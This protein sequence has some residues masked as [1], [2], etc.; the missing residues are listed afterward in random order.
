[1]KN[2]YSTVFRKTSS[3]SENLEYGVKNNTVNLSCRLDKAV[4]NLLVSDA[5]KRGISINSLVN[6]IAKKYISWERHA[7]DIGFVPL[8]KRAVQKIFTELDDD[9]IKAIATDVGSTVPRDLLMLN[10]NKITFANILILLETWDERF[11]KVRHEV[12]DSTHYFTVYHEINEKFSKYIA[13]VH[14]AMADDL[15]FKID[16]TNVTFNAVSFSIREK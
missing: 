7:D 8:T 14:Q 4:Y 1:M 16:I 6:N 10:F 9:K 15:S 11:G 12:A 13:C 2:E 5:Q 3:L